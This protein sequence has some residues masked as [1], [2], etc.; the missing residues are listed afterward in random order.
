MVKRVKT[1]GSAGE[2]SPQRIGVAALQLIDEEGLE[3]LSA[4]RVASALGC[5]AMSLYHHVKGMDGVRD[6]VVD[7]LFGAIEEEAALEPRRRLAIYARNFFALAEAHPRA[8]PLIATRRWH[9]PN[10]IAAAQ[11]AL[12][13]FESLGLTRREALRRVRVFGAYLNGAGLARAAW[14]EAPVIAP[15]PLKGLAAAQSP[16][17]VARDLDTGLSLLLDALCQT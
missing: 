3:A 6:Q 4:R 10:A 15:A 2:L 12:G 13:A 16:E 14:R 7:C 9:T 17:G 8:F 5:E 11:L 1:I